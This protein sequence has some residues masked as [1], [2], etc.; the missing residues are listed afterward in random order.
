VQTT[1]RRTFLV[2]ERLHTQADAIDAAF[3]Q[4]L[5]HRFGDGAGRTFHRDFRR[6][7]DIEVVA[8]RV[9][10]ALQLI[11]S[12]HRRRASAEVDRIDASI[13]LASHFARDC[14]GGRNL[15]ADLPHIAVKYRAREYTGSE[16]AEAALR[17]T[18]WNRDG[19]S[20]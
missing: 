3:E 10:E 14:V 5:Q 20:Q 12:K 8:Q 7:L 15:G 19:N 4:R 13:Q 16:I 18:E 9:K 2:H 17:A 1:H 6:T 11:G